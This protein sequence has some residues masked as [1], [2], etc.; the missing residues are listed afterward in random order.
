MFDTPVP[1]H[2][3]N[4]SLGLTT[5]LENW[6]G[7]DVT[8]IFKSGPQRNQEIID[9]SCLTKLL[10]FFGKVNMHVDNG[11]PIAQQLFHSV[12]GYIHD[13]C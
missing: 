8:R 11:E 10:D 5:Q 4:L 9:Q 3:C 7:A 12:S 13:S 6:N 2:T 1:T